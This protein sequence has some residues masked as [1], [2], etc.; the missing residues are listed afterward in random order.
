MCSI[1]LIPLCKSIGLSIV[2]HIP[3]GE[4]LF[5]KTCTVLPLGILFAYA[6][7][8]RAHIL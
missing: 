3:V 1:I 8:K 6:E 7:D 5:K 2:F 4:G